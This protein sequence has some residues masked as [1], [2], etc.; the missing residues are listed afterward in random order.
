LVNY[1]DTPRPVSINLAG[2]KGLGKTGRAQTLANA[3]LQTQN[4]LKEPK[5]LAPQEAT[6]AV[7]GSTL[8]YTLAPYSFTVLRALVLPGAIEAAAHGVGY[9]LGKLGGVA[10]VVPAVALVHPGRLGEARQ[11]L[12]GLDG[13]VELR[14]IGLELGV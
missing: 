10:Q 9:F 12:H 2:A 3:D 1:S 4:S 14:H 11:A 8:S 5:K 7:K 6:F 13:A